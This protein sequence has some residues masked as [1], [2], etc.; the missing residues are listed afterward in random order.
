MLDNYEMDQFGVVH[1]IKKQVFTYNSNYI[2]KGYEA[3]KPQILAMSKLRLGYVVGS[4]GHVPQTVLDVGYGFGNFL[5]SCDQLGIVTHGCDLFSDLLPAHAKFV[6][7]PTHGQ[8]DLITFFDSLEHFESVDFVKHLNAKFVAISLP[9][10]H[11]PEDNMWFSQ[12]HHRK[13]DEHLH[14]FNSQS[15]SAFM[16]ANGWQCVNYTHVEDV[17][18]K[19]RDHRPNILSAVFSR[20]H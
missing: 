12:W 5:D 20:S 3:L 13:P 14:H 1:Q 6:S 16:L 7:H 4:L 19:P 9:W 11:H 18:R 2:Y 17:I 8:Y 10:C 15:L